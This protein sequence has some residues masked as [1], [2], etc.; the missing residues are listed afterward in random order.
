M[1]FV[2]IVHAAGI[3]DAQATWNKRTQQKGGSSLSSPAPSLTFL[4][5]QWRRIAQGKPSSLLMR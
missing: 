3:S 2:C 5:N 4:P 1:F